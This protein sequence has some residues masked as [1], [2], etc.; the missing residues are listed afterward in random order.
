M[1]YQFIY[2]H[3]ILSCFF[4]YMSLSLYHLVYLS[5]RCT[6]QHIG[7]TISMHHKHVMSHVFH[8]PCAMYYEFNMHLCYISYTLYNWYPDYSYMQF[9][10]SH[11]VF[12]H[13]NPIP[14]HT[15]H[16]KYTYQLS[17]CHMLCLFVYIYTYIYIHVYIVTYHVNIIYHVSYYYI[18]FS[19]AI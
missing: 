7:F 15:I 5:F 11:A 4:E 2:I 6:M 8:L 16:I 10:I 14:C 13:H 12:K 3:I 1:Y 18:C 17:V 9:L 19:F